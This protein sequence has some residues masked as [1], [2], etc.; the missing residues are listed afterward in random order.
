MSIRLYLKED[1]ND[2]VKYKE[3]NNH[4]DLREYAY[5]LTIKYVNNYRR[6]NTLWLLE[7]E[8]INGKSGPFK[9]VLHIVTFICKEQWKKFK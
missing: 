8:K 7:E 4:S 5:E 6:S 1:F 3:I 9:H 2:S